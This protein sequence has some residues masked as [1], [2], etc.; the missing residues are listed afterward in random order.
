MPLLPY[1][2]QIVAGQ[3]LSEADSQAAMK[4]VLAGLA[5]APQLAALLMGMRMK[6]TTVNELVGFAR[7]MRRHAFPVMAA[8]AHLA[9][10][11]AESPLVDPEGHPA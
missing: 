3:E 6:G 10:A 5:S 1:I 4:L 2:E 7:A 8:H 9:A 11:S